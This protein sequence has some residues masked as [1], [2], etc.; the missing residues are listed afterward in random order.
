[1]LVVAHYPFSTYSPVHY[2]VVAFFA[3][4]L[5][6][7]QCR[8][9][10]A[11]L[12]W[13][14]VRT[15]VGLVLRTKSAPPLP[16]IIHVVLFN[17]H[18]QARWYTYSCLRRLIGE[19]GFFRN[20]RSRPATVP[21]RAEARHLKRSRKI[22]R[23]LGVLLWTV[24][25][26]LLL[27]R[28]EAA[29]EVE[30]VF[31]M[32]SNGYART[33]LPDGSYKPETYTLMKGGNLGGDIADPSI[34]RMTFEKMAPPIVRGL[35]NRNYIP[36]RD[37]KTLQLYIVIY[38]GTTW[39]PAYHSPIAEVEA[40]RWPALLSRTPP[41]AAAEASEDS[42]RISEAMKLLGYMSTS[43]PDLTSPRYF[44][45]L[46]AYDFQTKLK[47]GKEKLLWETRISIDEKGN[48]FDEAFPRMVARASSYFGK[49]SHGL[50]RQSLSVANVSIGKIESLGVVSE[51]KRESSP[52]GSTSAPPLLLT[53]RDLGAPALAPDGDRVAFLKNGDAELKLVIVDLDAEGRSVVVDLSSRGAAGLSLTWLDAEH[54][55]VSLSD[56]APVSVSIA[57]K[58]S[59]LS[60][61]A[62]ESAISQAPRSLANDEAIAPMMS[63]LR[64]KLS[65]RMVDI[66][67]V[68]TAR[69]RCLFAASGPGVTTRYFVYDRSDE[70][71]TEVGSP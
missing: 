9:F 33:K 11:L 59:K 37:V 32:L 48:Q 10:N 30:A 16:L 18:P 66:L 58:I 41:R 63:T 40:D 46:L 50:E 64:E 25:A 69:R 19:R 68:D 7:F 15:R 4:V 1:M 44:V 70:V 22:G 65:H 17:P 34:D 20:N 28:S 23:I 39:A 51:A 45:V 21:S 24:G 5:R 26:S 60:G 36:S 6:C 53:E 12:A 52:T 13:V 43:D 57:G 47:H 14:R 61:N 54:V 38:W 56:G 71:M 31:S 27:V 67:G 35:A 55:A 29:E 62:W 2:H 8:F 49:Y 3:P 42:S